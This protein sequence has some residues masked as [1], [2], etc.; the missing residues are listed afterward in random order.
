MY[1]MYI[2]Y[3]YIGTLI[4]QTIVSSSKLYL[5]ATKNVTVSKVSVDEIK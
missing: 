4:G 2:F 1:N 3:A 5:S